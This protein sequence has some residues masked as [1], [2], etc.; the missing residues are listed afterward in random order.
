MNPDL[1]S[2]NVTVDQI[3]QGDQLLRRF[4]LDNEKLTEVTVISNRKEI[5]E[6]TATLRYEA[7]PLDQ[8]VGEKCEGWDGHSP[9]TLYFNEDGQFDHF[10]KTIGATAGAAA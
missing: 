10:E 6:S 4:N 2:V 1:L 3:N 8:I 9:M 7:I 5:P